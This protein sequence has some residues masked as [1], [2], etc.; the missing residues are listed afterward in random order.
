VC[1]D[2]A[3]AKRVGD[4]AGPVLLHCPKI[5]AAGECRGTI[6]GAKEPLVDAR[7]LLRP[8]RLPGVRG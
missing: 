1:V 8:S 5:C 3:V 6:A 4:S 2:A 7:S